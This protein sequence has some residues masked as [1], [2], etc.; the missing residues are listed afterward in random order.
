M[1]NF[2]IIMIKIYGL[3]IRPIQCYKINILNKLN[4]DKMNILGVIIPCKKFHMKNHVE[5]QF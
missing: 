5:K 2:H 3:K 1:T 4:I